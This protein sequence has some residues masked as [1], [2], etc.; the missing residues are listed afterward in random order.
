M[1]AMLTWTVHDF[2]G[3]ANVSGWSTK[4][5]L[6][7]PNCHKGTYSKRLFMERSGVIWD[8]VGS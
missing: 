5:F 4:G 3:Y 2:P 6:A 7:C 1:F 8:V